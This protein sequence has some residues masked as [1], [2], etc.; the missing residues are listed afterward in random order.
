MDLTRSGPGNPVWTGTIR[1]DDGSEYHM[2]FINTGTGKSFER[3]ARPNSPARFFEEIWVIDDEPISAS[4]PGAVPTDVLLSGYD[5]GTTNRTTSRYHM[6]GYVMVA[7][8]PFEGL[9]GRSVHM[10]GMITWDDSGRPETAPG[11][12]RIH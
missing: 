12:F 1:L 10:R 4:T 8:G 7:N 3:T 11:T 9:E 5:R 6:S 2:A